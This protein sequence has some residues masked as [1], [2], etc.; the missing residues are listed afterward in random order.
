MEDSIEQHVLGI[1]ERKRK[2]MSLAFAEKQT[3]KGKKS[4]STVANI[5]RLLGVSR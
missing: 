4:D 1:Q 2:L 5:E 3:Q